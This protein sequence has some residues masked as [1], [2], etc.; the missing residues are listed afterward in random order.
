MDL[1]LRERFPEADPVVRALEEACDGCDT[2]LAGRLLS[3]EGFPSKGRR[4]W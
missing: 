3:K 4:R 1:A 2:L